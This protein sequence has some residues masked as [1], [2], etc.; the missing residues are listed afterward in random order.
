[1]SDHVS[2]FRQV[3]MSPYTRDNRCFYLVRKD[4][5]VEDFSYLKCLRQRQAASEGTAAP[6]SL[7]AEGKP[8]T[9]DSELRC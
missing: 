8:G 9:A 2:S 1:M 7:E 3:D 6:S 4:G 5:T